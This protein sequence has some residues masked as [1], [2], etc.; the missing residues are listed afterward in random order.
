M[1][2]RDPETRSSTTEGPRQQSFRVPVEYFIWLLT[3]VELRDVEH[4]P[5]ANHVFPLKGEFKRVCS[6]SGRD[7]LWAQKPDREETT[8]LK[9]TKRE[10]WRCVVMSFHKETSYFRRDTA[11]RV[12]SMTTGL[13]GGVNFGGCSLLVPAARRHGDV[14]RN[15]GYNKKTRHSSV[16]IS[17]AKVK[18][19]RQLL[20]YVS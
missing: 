9:N 11:V 2:A 16:I 13:G 20:G 12:L 5:P 14:D 18:S 4:F 7:E 1:H 10:R 17:E 15:P 6:L 3:C 8:T 19:G